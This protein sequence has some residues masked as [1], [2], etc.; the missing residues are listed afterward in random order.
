M[1]DTREEL[2]KLAQ[3]LR[4]KGCPHELSYRRRKP[5][6]A[7]GRWLVVCGACGANVNG[8]QKHVGLAD[9]KHLPVIVKK[10]ALE[11]EQLEL[12]VKE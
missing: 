9:C 4:A 1:T 12:F 2:L 7:R 8:S 10:Q 6:R 3:L 11:A 5:A